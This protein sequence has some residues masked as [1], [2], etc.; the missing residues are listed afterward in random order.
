MHPPHSNFPH[1][2]SATNSEK[3]SVQEFATRKEI[4]KM[5]ERN[6]S[7]SLIHCAPTPLSSRMDA[8]L[9][10]PFIPALLQV[11]ALNRP[12]VPFES[13]CSESRA[14][15]RAVQCSAVQCIAAL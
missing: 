8:P 15:A 13:R 14:V 12:T 10:V 1:T 3:C 5:Q 4:S 7:I 9:S 2:H 6:A 11:Q